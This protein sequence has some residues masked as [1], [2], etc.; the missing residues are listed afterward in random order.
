MGALKGFSDWGG[1]FK[2]S[3]SAAW[4]GSCQAPGAVEA[5]GNSVGVGEL[6][7]LLGAAVGGIWV[8]GV[9]PVTEYSNV[10]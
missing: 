10:R 6:P 5:G 8:L 1:G 9:E 2:T 3:P 4:S 7:L